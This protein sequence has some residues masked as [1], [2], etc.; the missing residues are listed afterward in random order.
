[1]HFCVLAKAL[2]TSGGNHI[3]AGTVASKL[4]GKCEITLGFADSLRDDFI[5]KDQ[6]CVMFFAQNW[7][8]MPGVYTYDFRRYSCLAYACPN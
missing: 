4:E 1:M 6:N 5:E 7:V 3:H 2:R 8:F